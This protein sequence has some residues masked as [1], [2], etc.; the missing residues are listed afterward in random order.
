MEYGTF[1]LILAISYVVANIVLYFAQE[2][3]LFKPEKLPEDFEFKYPDLEFEEY[4]LEKEPG[5]NINGI[6]FKI[7]NPKMLILETPYYSL[8]EVAKRYYPIYPAK[9]ALR[10]NF[11]SFAYLEASNCPI[12]IF[13]GTEDTIVPYEQGEQLAGHLKNKEVELIT[14]EGGAHRNLADF[15]LYHE[16]VASILN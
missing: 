4:N 15:P 7:D 6:H 5:V 1:L 10:Y 2:R 12:F 14:I 9:L 8:S 11:R 13:H 3:F 16:K